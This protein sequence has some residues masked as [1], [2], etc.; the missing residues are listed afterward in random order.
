M[1]QVLDFFASLLTV[2][3]MVTFFLFGFALI[4]AFPVMWCWNYVIPVI[5]DLPRINYMQA[6]TLYL[7]CGFLFKQTKTIERKDN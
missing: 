4:L 1:K 7:L 6:L 5:T 2:V 3:G